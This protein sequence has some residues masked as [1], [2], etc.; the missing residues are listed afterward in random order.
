MRSLLRL[1]NYDGYRVIDSRVSTRDQ[2]LEVVLER[3]GSK[4][5]DCRV[6]GCPLRQQRGSYW[7]RL[8]E[9]S[10]MNFKT[11]VKLRRQKAH[12]PNCR[13]ARSEKIDFIAEATPHLTAQY[14]EWMGMMCEFSPVSRVAKFCGHSEGRV[15]NIDYARMRRYLKKYKIP[16]ATH[17]AVDEVYAR[18]K[19]RKGENRDKRFFTVITDLDTRKVIWVSES[20]QKE[21]LDEF[22]QMIGKKACEDIKVVAIDQHDGYRKSVGQHCPQATVVWDRFHLMQSFNEALNEE[23]KTLHDS[24]EKGSDIKELTRAKYKYIFLRK[25]SR[26]T[27]ADQSHIDQVFLENSKFS[28]LEIIKEFFYSFFDQTSEISALD[29]FCELGRW[30]D[31]AGFRIIKNWYRNLENNW[32]TLKNYFRFK[33]TSALAEGVNNVIKTLKRRAYG[34]RDMDYFRLKIMQVCGYLNSDWA[35]KQGVM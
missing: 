19:P 18:R 25:P 1:F 14:A 9:L 26:R 3:K 5:L 34:Y 35:G 31:Q 13:K 6:C 21:A 24:F 20:R 15:R 10:V 2:T 30:V 4:P 28:Q 29:I 8:R 33:V 12:C 22:F 27:K 16:P 32:E 23:R 11:T 7:L 17:I